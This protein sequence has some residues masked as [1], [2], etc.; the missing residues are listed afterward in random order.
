MQAVIVFNYGKSNIMKLTTWHIVK[1]YNHGP[2]PQNVLAVAKENV[3][4]Y[5]TKH[6]NNAA[7]K[8]NGLENQYK[9]S[10]ITVDVSW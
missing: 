10:V 6:I 5:T 3:D 4:E 8:Y 1:Y 7:S 9:Q 2:S